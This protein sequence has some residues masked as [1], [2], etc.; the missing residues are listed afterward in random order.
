[1]KP[2][3]LLVAL[4]LVSSSF[5][6]GAKMSNVVLYQPGSIM[7]ERVGDVAPLAA[8]IQK[9]QSV[10][11]EAFTSEEKEGVDV[12]VVLKP[13]GR[14]RVW[15][16]SSLVAKPDRSKLKSAIE[17]IRPPTVSGPVVFALAYDLNGFSHPVQEAGKFQPSIPAE[18]TD[19]VKGA[20]GPLM[21]PDG[22]IPY[23][24]PDEKKG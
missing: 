4:G 17:A 23:V 12:V 7:K 16:V 11:A 2:F 14:S 8:F 13:G 1:M 5:A 10:C 3:I 15:F 22:F 24:W 21:I 9:V 18:W 20:K 19:S 6:A